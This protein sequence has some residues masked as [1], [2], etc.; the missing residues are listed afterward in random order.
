MKK[1]TLTV[2]RKA[3]ISAVDPRLYG[4]FIEH[5]GRAVYG[6]VYQPDHPSADSD[7][8]RNDALELVRELNV[9]VIRYPGGNFV[10]GY[11]WEDG[12]GAP[13]N[14]PVR[15]D[16]AWSAVENNRV[17]LQE[18]AKWTEKAGSELMYAVNLGSGGIDAARN[19]VE[20]A[21]HP[22]GTYYSDLRRK[23]GRKEPYGIK[24]W[25]LGNEMDGSWQ[26][27]AKTAT[28]YGRLAAECAKVM[29]WVD[30]GIELVA[31]GS[32][33]NGMPTF[34]TWETEVLEHT[35]EHVDYLSLHSYYNNRD[36]DTPSF[37]ARSLEM[38]DFIKTVAAICDAVKGR[39]KS[40]KSIN[41]S[42]DEWNVW[43]HSNDSDRAIPKWETAP[44]RL[45]DIYNFEDALL[46]GGLLITL[47]N[48]ADR[49]KI[50]CIAQLINVIAP[51][52]TE[53]KGG[54]WRQTIYYPFLHASKFGRGEALRV[55]IKSPV[56]DCKIRESVNMLD[57]VAVADANGGIT[58][59]VLNRSLDDDLET[60]ITVQGAN[61]L[62]WHIQMAGYGLKTANS[63]SSQ[64]VSPVYAQP[65]R[66]DGEV[67]KTALP[68]ASWNVL[69]FE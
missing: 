47:I 43:Y 62:A 1:A 22:G 2:D 58:V 19:V 49:V 38:D 31:C 17:G 57:S 69:R 41:L 36:D 23:H 35:Y 25:C 60:E 44:P 5:L 54:A 9:P 51:I 6:G 37:L 16:L 55:D 32:S 24:L 48:N 68:K 46:V 61:K 34:G 29:K 30:N 21:N 14:R 10:S 64:A 3:R 39:K 12:I 15:L 52:M 13:E 45:E 33:F 65:G 20:Y 26:I 56:Y 11:N 28:E 67:Y 4:S 53:P 63:P 7:G 66:M 42:F 50:A 40:R 27:G 59:F 8:F 18:F